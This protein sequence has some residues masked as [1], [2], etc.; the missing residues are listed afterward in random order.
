MFLK[1]KHVSSSVLLQFLAQMKSL[2]FLTIYSS[3][4]HIIYSSNSFSHLS[5]FRTALKLLL[6]ILFILFTIT[7][8]R[9][10]IIFIHIQVLLVFSKVLTTLVNMCSWRFK[11]IYGR[12]DI[13]KSIVVVRF[14]EENFSSTTQI[15]FIRAKGHSDQNK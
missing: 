9:L 2:R 15:S 11:V 4:T 8:C 5:I 14:A 6:N 3:S 7:K 12:L 13:M 10:C 1:M